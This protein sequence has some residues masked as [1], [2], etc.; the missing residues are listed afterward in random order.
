METIKSLTR[1]H[2][3]ILLYVGEGLL[4]FVILI[5]LLICFSNSVS[6]L[7][8]DIPGRIVKMMSL[9]N[10]FVFVFCVLAGVV[11]V[12]YSNF[13]TYT[14]LGTALIGLAVVWISTTPSN[15][16]EAVAELG[17][18]AWD[19]NDFSRHWLITGQVGTGKTV[20]AIT[21]LQDSVFKHNPH[22][23]GQPGWGGVCVDDKGTYYEFIQAMAEYHDRKGDLIL[24]QTRPEWADH[25]WRPPAIFNPLSDDRIPA[26]TYADAIATCYRNASE[27]GESNAFFTNQAITNIGQGIELFRMLGRFPC[28][29]EINDVL[30]DSSLLKAAIAKVEERLSKGEISLDKV[31]RAKSVINHFKGKYLNQPEE[32]LGGIKS[33]IGNY[34]AYFGTPDVVE[35]FGQP[36]GNTVNF[37]EIDNGKIFCVSMPQKYQIERRYVGSLLIV[38]F[39]QHAKR[40]F[41]VLAE[42]RKKSNLLIL[43]ADEGQRFLSGREDADILREAGAAIVVATQMHEGFYPGMRREVADVFMGNLSNRVIFRPASSQ[44]AEASAQFLGK[45]EVWKK[46]YS[47]GKGGRSVSRHKEEE[48]KVKPLHLLNERRFPKFTAVVYHCSKGY[49]RRKLKPLF[50]TTLKE[51]AKEARE[52]REKKQET[53][54]TGQQ[55]YAR[56]ED[57][58]PEQAKN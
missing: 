40:R 19:K 26:N 54:A 35:V 53:E 42:Q 6:R 2:P 43:W 36:A 11:A 9:G 37:S 4:G 24:L 46:S 21:N 56:V 27:G 49:R 1:L 18:Y 13:P 28:L 3:Q 29:H 16:E 38:L 52:A 17:G 45:K 31:E 39:L 25:S 23:N 8:S 41:D 12:H 51:R 10:L 58:C 7:F 32:Q 33:T 15:K 30:Q 47:Y 5:V 44:S 20:A 34:L 48:Y 50:V 57:V 55:T 14:T 22:R